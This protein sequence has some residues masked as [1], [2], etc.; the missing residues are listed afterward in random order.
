MKYKILLVDDSVDVK[1]VVR[2]TLSEIADIDVATSITGTMNLMASG[3]YDLILMDV[4]LEDGDGFELT[5]KL[6]EMENSK[7][8]PVI[9]LTGKSD[10]EAKAKGFSLGAED[11]IETA[12]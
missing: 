11:Y 12:G 7:E 5:K 2:N 3:S 4:G 9:F 6:Q 8:T 10:I 1:E